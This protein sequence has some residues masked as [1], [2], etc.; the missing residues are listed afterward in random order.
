MAVV[1]L[2]KIVKGGEGTV[3]AMVMVI[4]MMVFIG[5]VMGHKKRR[6]RECC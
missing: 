5:R 6:E 3:L 2:V 1:T 4:M